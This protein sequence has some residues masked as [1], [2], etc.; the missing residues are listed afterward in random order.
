MLENPRIT[1]IMTDEFFFE[2][3]TIAADVLPSFL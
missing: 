1:L 2:D 3:Q